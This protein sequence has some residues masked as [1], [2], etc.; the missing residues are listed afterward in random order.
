MNDRPEKLDRTGVFR[1]MCY[2]RYFEREVARACEQQRVPGVVYLAVG[3]ESVAATVSTLTRGFAVFNQHRC[4]SIYLAHGGSPEVLRDELLGL[5]SGCCGGRGGSPSAQDPAIPMFAYHGL[6]GEHIPLAAGYALATSQPTVVYFGD[7]GS[8]EDY[9]LTAFGF[10]A[11]HALP[12][13]FVCEDNDL[14]ILTPVR[15]RR[16]WQVTDVVRSMGLGCAEVEDDPEQIFQATHALLPRLPA[17]INV[18]TCRH[19]WH[20]GTGVDGEPAQDRLH[21][22]RDGIV[23]A[24]EIEAGAARAARRL[25][26]GAEAPLA[27]DVCCRTG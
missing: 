13:L 25:W 27:A 7:A 1:R 15:D 9:A 5:E 3:Q 17:F 18:K 23:G 26:R 6:I 22:M 2:I 12:V 19:L 11:T 21:L 10:A 14:S 4:H 24:H 8:E 16:N 20:A